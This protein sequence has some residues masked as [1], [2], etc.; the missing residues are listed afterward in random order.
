MSADDY[1]VLC[2]SHTQ[3]ECT[4]VCI[5][6]TELICDDCVSLDHSQHE[7]KPIKKFIKEVDLDDLKE[8]IDEFEGKQMRAKIQEET[9]KRFQRTMD[10]INSQASILISEINQIKE[11]KILECE[12]KR[13][14]NEVI[15]NEMISYVD[16]SD[17]SK[18]IENLP[19]KGGRTQYAEVAKAILNYQKQIESEEFELSCDASIY[20][21][22]FTPG[23]IQISRLEKQFGKLEFQE[24]SVEDMFNSEEET[25]ES[26]SDNNADELSND[27]ANDGHD[28]GSDF[29][30]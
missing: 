24:E 1:D 5:D 4:F 2:S 14:K 6:C 3:E 20:T 10:A 22:T 12:R 11:K 23:K 26:D 9:E 29:I 21:P 8:R 28:H 27:S 30:E 7:I 25:S 16:P 19:Q 13:S 18:K 17:I 15:A